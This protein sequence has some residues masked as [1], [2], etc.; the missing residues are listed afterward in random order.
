MIT[1]VR[2]GLPKFKDAV[3]VCHT[4]TGEHFVVSTIESPTYETLVFPARSSGEVIDW[5]EVAGGPLCTREDAVLELDR[6]IN[7]KTLYRFELEG[8]V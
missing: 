4:D 5:L 3:L 1:I 7:D 6:R 8:D 2:E